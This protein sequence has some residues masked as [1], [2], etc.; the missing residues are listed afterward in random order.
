MATWR[1]CQASEGEKGNRTRTTAPGRHQTWLTEQVVEIALWSTVRASDGEKGGPNMSFGA[2]GSPLPSQV[3]TV[4]NTSNAPMENG[5]GSLHPE[6]AGWEL[7]YP[8]EWISCAP[9]ETRSIIARR[10]SSSAPIST[11]EAAE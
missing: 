8:P 6:F 3:S 1:T 10:R 9:S 2:G 7:G 5:G 11:Q 4:A